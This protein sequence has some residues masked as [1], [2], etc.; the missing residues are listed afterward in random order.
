MDCSC[1]TTRP[2][3]GLEDV[4]TVPTSPAVEGRS[5]KGCKRRPHLAGR[6]ALARSSDDGGA[7]PPLGVRLRNVDMQHQLSGSMRDYAGVLGAR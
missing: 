2:R 4:A 1:S 5:S 7:V 3:R 6:V